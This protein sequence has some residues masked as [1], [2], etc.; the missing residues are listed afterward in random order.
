MHSKCTQNTVWYS[1]WITKKCAKK[2]ERT[3]LNCETK[4]GVIITKLT[5]ALQRVSIEMK[6]ILKLLLC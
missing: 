5:D 1:N 6:V 2:F 4:S 3:P